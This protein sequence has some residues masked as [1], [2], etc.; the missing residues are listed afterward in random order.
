MFY[1]LKNLLE[2][3]ALFGFEIKASFTEP[4]ISANGLQIKE[5]PTCRD[6]G[7]SLISLLSAVIRSEQSEHSRRRDAIISK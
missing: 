7:E 2:M 3:S 6:L 4:R 5:V 1:I